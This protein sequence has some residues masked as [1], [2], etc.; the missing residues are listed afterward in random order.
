L[1]VSIDL[2]N[3]HFGFYAGQICHALDK[4]PFKNN[5]YKCR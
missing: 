4:S 3:L 5:K 1:E 2:M